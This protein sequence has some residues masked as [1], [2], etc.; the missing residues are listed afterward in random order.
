MPYAHDKKQICCHHCFHT[1]AANQIRVHQ[2]PSQQL[3]T[4][5]Q[6]YT[7]P[8]LLIS[9]LLPAAIMILCAACCTSVQQGASTKSYCSFSVSVTAA[10]A[11]KTPSSVSSSSSSGGYATRTAVSPSLLSHCTFTSKSVYT[12]AAYHISC[13]V[14][15][16]HVQDIELS[17]WRANH[18]KL[19]AGVSVS[20]I[21]HDEVIVAVSSSSSTTVTAS[22]ASSVS[23][24][25]LHRADSLCSQR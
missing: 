18:D 22:S 3:Q 9:M 23:T 21:Y 8:A 12:G 24:A 5:A 19:I 6:E 14:Y 2:H 7:E 1:A 15:M 4:I 25:R 20:G 16:R 11:M 10:A 17:Q 13:F